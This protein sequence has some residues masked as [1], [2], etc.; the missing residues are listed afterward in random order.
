MLRKPKPVKRVV[1]PQMV[2]RASRTET[3]QLLSWLDTTTISLGSAVDSW[4]YH[5]APKEDVDMCIDALYV[6][7]NELQ[8]RGT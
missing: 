8:T 2:G 7:W 6:I 1:S 5:N 3:G 4:R